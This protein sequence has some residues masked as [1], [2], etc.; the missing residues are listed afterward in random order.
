MLTLSDPNTT[1]DVLLNSPKLYPK[2]PR[3]QDVR[4]LILTNDSLLC[5]IKCFISVIKQAIFVP[6]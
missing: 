2:F 1:Q 4:T 5:K 3:K 6:G